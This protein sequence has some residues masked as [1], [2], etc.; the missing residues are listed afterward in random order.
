MENKLSRLDIAVKQRILDN[1]DLILN[2]NN[3]TNSKE[4]SMY[5]SPYVGPNWQTAQAYRNGIN[6]DFGV[7]ID[8]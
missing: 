2:L 8:L 3:L 6:L 5:K 1:I 4:E 7:R